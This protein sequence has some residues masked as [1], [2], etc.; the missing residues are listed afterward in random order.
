MHKE[1]LEY[2][3]ECRVLLEMPH[4]NIGSTSVDMKSEKNPRWIIDSFIPFINNYNPDEVIKVVSNPFVKLIF[5]KSYKELSNE[6]KNF[7]ES[8]ID[9]KLLNILRGEV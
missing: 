2:L 5:Q 4:I 3:L 6:D 7:I 8:N 9:L 1:Y